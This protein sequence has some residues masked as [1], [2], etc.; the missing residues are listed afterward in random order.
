[1]HRVAL[2]TPARPRHADRRATWV[3]A[4]PNVT[5]NTISGSMAPSAAA[6]IGLAGT[7]STSHC[8][9]DCSFLAPSAAAPM[10]APALARSDSAAAGSI[11]S[12]AKRGPDTTTP[13]VHAIASDASMY[14]S[15]RPPSRPIVRVSGAD[16]IPTTRLDTT[17]G[18]III[19]IAL[20]NIV[21]IG[22]TPRAIAASTALPLTDA[23]MPS[24]RPVTSAMR[25]SVVGEGRLDVISERT[26]RLRDDQPRASSTRSALTSASTSPSVLNRCVEMRC[27]LNQ[28]PGTIFTYT[29]WRTSSLSRRS[30]ALIAS[31]RR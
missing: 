17:S 29:R 3:S 12:S 27:P 16:V 8:D 31:G 28:F 1:M 20:T 10:L 18:M 30:P 5:E 23:A 15:A 2:R 22:S 4:M 21:P 24:P 26:D 7:R 14:A 11:G 25:T 19:R 9:I 13:I 6:L